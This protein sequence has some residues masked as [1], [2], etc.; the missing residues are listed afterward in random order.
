MKNALEKV[1]KI[2]V[3]I[4]I[5]YVVAATT[6]IFIDKQIGYIGIICLSV[7]LL[8][9]LVNIISRYAHIIEEQYKLLDERDLELEKI[10]KKIIVKPDKKE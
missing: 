3:F 7:L 2:I 5:S 9:Y 10:V 4:L 6:I 1:D 8:F